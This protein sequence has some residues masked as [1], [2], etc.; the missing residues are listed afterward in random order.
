M[1]AAPSLN[2]LLEPYFPPVPEIGLPDKIVKR[3]EEGEELK[4]VEGLAEI[5]VVYL[6]LGEI[7]KIKDILSEMAK[8]LGRARKNHISCNRPQTSWSR[9][10]AF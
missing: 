9:D 5:I 8:N 1:L 7:I 6:L 2:D 4:L 10:A 3:E